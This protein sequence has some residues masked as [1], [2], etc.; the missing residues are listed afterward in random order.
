MEWSVS[1]G[2]LQHAI[3]FRSTGLNETNTEY[4][5]NL[6][7][8]YLQ[9]H[10]FQQSQQNFDLQKEMIARY[11]YK[12]KM[13]ICFFYFFKNLKKKNAFWD[14]TP[15]PQVS[16]ES[17]RGLAASPY[18]KVTGCLSVCLYQRISKTPNRY[19]SPFQGSL[20]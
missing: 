6:L 1:L 19:V 12:A 5:A 15:P 2:T 14:S 18:N 4:Q 8:S 7:S 10:G 17:S 16:P 3:S 11:I 20:S 13:E 9:L